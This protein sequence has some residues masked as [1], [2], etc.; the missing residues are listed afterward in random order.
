MFGRLAAHKCRSRLGA[1]V[2]D[3][4]DDGGDALGNDLSAGDV[5]G[6]EEGARAGHND[7]VNDHAHEVEANRVV[8]VDR[9]GQGDF[10]AHAIRTR[11]QQWVPVF[12][13]KTDVEEA[14]ES[15]NASDNFGSVGCPNRGLHQFDGQVTGGRVYPRTRI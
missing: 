2:G 3:A 15:A 1:C 7:V 14:G 9:L 11:G 13:E 12:L 6:H 8:L 4:L 10:G 5:V